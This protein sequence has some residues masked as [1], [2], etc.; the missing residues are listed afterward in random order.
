[1]TICSLYSAKTVLLV[2]NT[3]L[4]HSE[5]CLKSD[6][7]WPVL[8]VVAAYLR[9]TGQPAVFYSGEEELVSMSQELHKEGQYDGRLRYYADGIVRINDAEV[10]IFEASSAYERCSAVKAT[11]DHYKAMFGMLG[12]LRNT[13][14]RYCHASFDTFTKLKIHFVHAHGKNNAGLIAAISH[15]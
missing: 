2:G 15:L 5:N 1:M 4:M 12:V 10:L 11:F 9:N 14:S 7:L 8:Q 3:T 13:A 6:A